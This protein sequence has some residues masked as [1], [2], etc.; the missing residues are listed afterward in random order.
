MQHI[1]VQAFCDANC[2]F[3]QFHAGG[4]GSTNDVSAS[5]QTLI[6]MYID[7]NYF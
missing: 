2:T 7:D 5:A 3:I 6:A 4:P 1:V